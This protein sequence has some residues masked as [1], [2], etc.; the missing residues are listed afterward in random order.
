MKKIFYKFAFLLF[1]TLVF[2]GCKENTSTKER[3]YLLDG[4]QYSLF[5]EPHEFYNIANQDLPELSKLAHN[6]HGYVFL[7]KT[8]NMPQELR[9]EE[10]SLYLGRVKIAAKV[11]INGHFLGQTGFF[12]PHEF[13]E[14]EKA[15]YFKIPKEYLNFAEKNTISIS[16][17]C[18]E[19]GAIQD[20]PF[21]ALSDDVI[22]KAEFDN[23]VNSKIYMIFSVVLIIIFFIYFFLFILRRSEI[24]NLS[25]SQLCLCTALYT[26]TFY[27]GEYSIIY[28]HIYSFLLFQKIFN[29]AAPILTSY[30]VINF[31]RDFLKHSERNFSKIGRG[32]LTGIALA[33]PF[34]ASDLSTSRILL[35]YGFLIMVVQF[36]YPT[37]ILLRALRKKESQAIKFI[38]CFVPVYAILFFECFN[39]FVLKRPNNILILS[40]AWLCVI[41]LFLGLL[42]VNFVNLAGKVEY[43]NK[44]LENLVE[45]RTQALEKESCH[46]GN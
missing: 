45:E 21:I 26:V 8:F 37:V 32:I 14:G 30:F 40:I 13:T 18:N 1:L 33:L 16:V 22:H 10:L 9:H 7:K 6:K 19:F 17:W 43:M 12:P 44:H 36:I 39:H 5:G 11:Y 34:M 24:E 23:L 46:S 15:G 38:L 31:T 35:R 42:I 41:F 29:E 3:F 4:W 20:I 25:F 27:I 2:T 28:K